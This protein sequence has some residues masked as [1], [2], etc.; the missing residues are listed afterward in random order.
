MK[1]FVAL[2]V[3]ASMLGACAKTA[4]PIDPNEIS[5]T[6]KMAPGPGLFSGRDGKFKAEF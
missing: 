4:K 5:R 6:D 1:Y 2:F 3:A